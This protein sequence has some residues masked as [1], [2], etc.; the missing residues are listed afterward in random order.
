MPDS[1]HRDSTLEPDVDPTAS[2]TPASFDAPVPDIDETSASLGTLKSVS[3]G[4]WILAILALIYTIFFAREF[5]IPIVY[6]VLLSFLLS[7]LIRLFSRFKIPPPVGAGI[8]ILS[9]LAVV[10]LTGYELAGPLGRFA[11]DAPHTLITAEAKL[12]KLLRPLQRATKT[13]EQVASAA[14]ATAA[15]T[16]GGGP[17]KPTQVVV[18]GPSVITRAFGTTQRVV[19]IVLEVTI[20]LYFLLAAGDLFLQKLIKVLP[21]GNEKQLAVQIARET[22]SSI[23]TYLV[24]TSIVNVVE[25]AVVTLVMWAWGMPSPF[26]WGALVA[27]FEFIPYLGAVAIIGLLTIAALTTYDSVGHALLIPASYLFINVIQGNFV[28]PVLLGHK[29]ALNPVAIFV[30]LTFWFWVWGIPGAFIAVPLM[31]TFKIFC[32]N[33]EVLASIGEFLGQRDDRERR[34]AVR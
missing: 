9:L 19:G 22:E 26:L 3:I 13:A 5:L 4:V 18:A 34:S 33:I 12:T 6:A 23:S 17:A 8:I 7:P 31:A 29:L 27:A 21:A 30:G 25:G 14:S 20:L 24:T 16:S 1:P 10:G 28:S 15:G 11:S 32:D 2:A